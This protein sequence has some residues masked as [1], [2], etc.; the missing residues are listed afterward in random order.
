MP[1][2]PFVANGFEHYPR[3]WHFSPALALGGFVFLSGITGVRPDGSLA[4]DPE[5]QFR[6]TFKFVSLHLQAAGLEFSD[7]VDLVTFHVELRRHLKTFIKVRDEF[8][9]PPY[10][11]W[12]AIGVAELITEGTLLEIRAVASTA[13]R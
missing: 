3:D 12:T 11:T 1:K 4:A 5:I 6:D 2:K 9:A 7:I 8:I 13:G 10:P